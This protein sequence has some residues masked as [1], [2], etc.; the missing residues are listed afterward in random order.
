MPTI[1]VDRAG[2]ELANDRTS[3][4]IV[5]DNPANLRLLHTLLDERG[6]DVR[7]ATGGVSA[8]RSVRAEAPD[9]ILLDIE[10]PDLSGYDVCRELKK[11]STTRDVPIL[12]ISAAKDAEAK[13][14]S[15]QV[16]GVDYVTKPF[17][18]DEVLAR[19]DH[20]LTIH[21]QRRQIEAQA[22]RLRELDAVKSRFFAG[23]SHEFRTPLM[24]TR[25]L[26]QDVL[27]GR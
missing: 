14:Q 1:P 2:S 20:Q 4:L 15:F 7:V 23:I 17:Q 3:I 9:L 11:D 21:R 26:M 24:L 5:D 16:G 8:L 27:D 18:V 10:M 25:G 22:E 12:F 6:F 19:I 13:V